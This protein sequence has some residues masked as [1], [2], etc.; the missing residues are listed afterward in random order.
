MVKKTLNNT[1][2]A[3]K[4]NLSRAAVLC[5]LK[6]QFV[7]LGSVYY[8]LSNDNINSEH[9]KNLIAASQIWEQCIQG[10]RAA[11]VTVLRPEMSEHMW[12][13]PPLTA[14]R[15]GLFSES[16][17]REDSWE[18]CGKQRAL[19][20]GLPFVE[21]VVVECPAASQASACGFLSL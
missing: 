6:C 17:L 2:L 1:I 3:E 11:K 9:Q 18:N 16:F 13:W 20:K 14:A 5:H 19:V 8:V 4:V 15:H 21:R 10:K 7:Y 12:L